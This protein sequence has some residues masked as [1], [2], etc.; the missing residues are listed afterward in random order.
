MVGLVDHDAVEPDPLLC[1]SGLGAEVLRRFLWGTP[2]RARLRPIDQHGVPVH[3]TQVEARCGDEN[4]RRRGL[5]PCGSLGRRGLVVAR[6]D[7]NPVAGV[8]GVDGGLDRAVLAP[9]PVV[10][11]DP[12]DSRRRRGRGTADPNQ[13]TGCERRAGGYRD[14]HSRCG[15]PK[16]SRSRHSWHREVHRA[17]NPTY[18]DEVQTPLRRSRPRRRTGIPDRAGRG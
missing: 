12:Q 8:G 10:G 11:A 3:S 6:R 9:D 15:A 7:Q 4:P 1:V 18:F 16:P 17:R 14:R 2:R 5:R 13:R